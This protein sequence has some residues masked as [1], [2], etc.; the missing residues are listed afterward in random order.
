MGFFKNLL[1]RDE[2]EDDLKKKSKRAKEKEDESDEEDSEEE[3]DEDEEDGDE[4]DDTEETGNS[5]KILLTNNDDGMYEVEDL[6]KKE[7][8]ELKAACKRAM[9]NGTPLDLDEEGGYRTSCLNGKFIISY[10]WT[11][12]E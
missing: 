12:E 7:L 1:G 2:E 5:I 9:T 4:D 3:E 8:E 6:S 10:D 11:E